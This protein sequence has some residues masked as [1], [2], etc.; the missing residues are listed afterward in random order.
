M[1]APAVSVKIL[2]LADLPPSEIV[3]AA[4]ETIFW[5]TSARRQFATEAERLVYLDRWLGRY[6]KHFPGE[7]FVARA[8]TNEVVGYLVGC[9]SD[10]TGHPLFADVSYFSRFARFSTDYPAHL[11][12][13][14]KA[15]WRGRG[16]GKDLV[17]AFAG[18][19]AKSGAPGMHVVTGEGARNNSFYR[20]CGFQ[21]LGSVDWNGNR[22]AFFG[23]RLASFD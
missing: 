1:N 3:R 18:H 6:L 5:E 17:E 14:L 23:R 20:A 22:I 2:P 8:V 4:I 11:H 15:E 21:Q 9:L 19:A 10:P 13:N 7:A 16:I 12:I